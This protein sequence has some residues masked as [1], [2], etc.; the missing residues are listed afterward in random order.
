MVSFKRYTEKSHLL[1]GLSIVAASNLW[2]GV[3][4]AQV[5]GS[6]KNKF[7]DPFYCLINDSVY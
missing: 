7:V 6:G 4:N 1:Y 3:A 2:V 5:D